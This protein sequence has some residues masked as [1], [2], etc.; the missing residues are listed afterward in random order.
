M[1]EKGFIPDAELMERLTRIRDERSVLE[2]KLA[3]LTDEEPDEEHLDPDLLTRDRGAPR[4]GL[5]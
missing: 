1:R 2:D 5:D 3:A 4:R